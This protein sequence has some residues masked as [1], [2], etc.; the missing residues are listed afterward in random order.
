M[1]VGEGDPDGVIADWFDAC[2]DD[3]FLASDPLP[4]T[5]ALDFRAGA[6]NP[7]KFGGQ[8][9]SGAVIKNNIQEV[10]GAPEFNLDWRNQG[11]APICNG[12]RPG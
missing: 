9:R 4:V 5:V 3:M 8:A 11:P 1:A 2:N 6:F 7:Q 10:F 12:K